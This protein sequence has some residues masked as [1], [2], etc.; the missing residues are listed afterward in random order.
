FRKGQLMSRFQLSDE[1][2][3]RY[4]QDG[5]LIVEGFLDREEVQLLRRIAR[6]DQRLA[7]AG[8]RRDGQGKVV[9]L[10]VHNDLPDDIYGAVGRSRRLVEAMERLLTGEVYH[11]HHKM[12]LKEPHVG[13]AW[14]WH[15]DYGYW[16][17]NG[18][19]YPLMAS[20]MIAVDRATRANGCLQV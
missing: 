17:Q 19:L 6:A 1:Q 3:E 11:Y 15:Q 9:K 16:Y 12:I 4:E 2:L 5:Y 13:G 8:S 20:C 10:A 18:C 7:T 14:E